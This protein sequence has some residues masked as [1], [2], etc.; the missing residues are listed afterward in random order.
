MTTEYKQILRKFLAEKALGWDWEAILK[1]T[2]Q[3]YEFWMSGDVGEIR[4]DWWPTDCHNAAMLLLKDE[5]H[6][7][8][9]EVGGRFACGLDCGA[10]GIGKTMQEAISLAVAE[11]HGWLEYQLA[12][13]KKDKW[14]KEA[15]R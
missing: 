4:Q 3:T 11:K 8:I 5:Q 12:L 10:S 14:P 6:F 7:S 13:M 9:R 15:V 2:K 1:Q